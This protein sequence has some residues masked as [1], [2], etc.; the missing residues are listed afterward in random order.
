MAYAQRLRSKQCVS[1]EEFDFA[2]SDEG[3]IKRKVSKKKEEEE[4]KNVGKQ[5]SPIEVMKQ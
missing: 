3:R 5:F 2:V 4:R 1:Y